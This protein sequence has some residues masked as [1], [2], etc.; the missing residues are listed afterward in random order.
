[1]NLVPHH[2]SHDPAPALPHRRRAI[3]ACI[4]LALLAGPV[5]AAPATCDRPNVS[6]VN[7]TGV[8]CGDGAVATGSGA[9]A[10]GYMSKAIGDNAIALGNAAQGFAG[11]SLALGAG[12]VVNAAA[13]GSIAL[14]A[15]SVA[16]GTT[17]ATPAYL[18]G[19]TAPS[20]L[21]IGGRRI[22]GVADGAN[23][24]D[25]AT[26]GQLKAANVG[27]DLAVRYAW[28]DA[29]G[30]KMVD[31]GEIDYS[32]VILG[33]DPKTGVPIAG[34]VTVS[35]VKNG[36]VD[37]TST[38]A[39]NGS[40]LFGVK[41]TADTALLTANKGWNVS[42]DSGAAAN[43]GPGGNVAFHSTDG[44][45]AVSQSGKA[46]AGQVDLTLSRNL[47]LDS[48]T[49][50]GTVMNATGLTITGGPSVTVGGINANTTRISNLAAGVA[51]GDAVN[52]SQLG[53]VRKIAETGWDVSDEAGS[54]ANI[55]PDGKITFKSADSNLAVAQKGEDDNGVIEVALARNLDLGAAGSVTMGTTTVDAA[56]LA[57]TGGPSVTTT[58]IS[59]GSQAITNVANGVADT[60]AVNV[61]QL[62]DVRKTAEA[63]WN[64][65]DRTGSQV[66]IGANGK[67]TFQSADA[68]LGVVQKGE[69]DEGVVEVQLAK[70]LDLG[71][72]GSVV[73]GTTTVNAAG[74]AIT[75]GPSVTTTGID[76]GTKTIINV[77]NGVADNDAVNMSQ[78]EAVKKSAS[79]GWNVA[80][81]SGNAANISPE[82][83][84]TFQSADANLAVTQKG[85]DDEGIVEV[86]LAKNLD[87]GA[88]GSMAMG[89][90]TINATG[91]FI[92]GGPSVTTT[93]INAG[94]KVVTNLADGV[95]DS[96]AVNMSQLG[97]VSKA[98][99]A[100]WNVADEAGNQ[101]NI[102]P[103]GTVTFKSAD[104]NLTVTQKGGNDD[105]VVE[106]QLAKNLDLGA[107][108]SVAMGTTTV[109][110]TG[111]T[112]AGGPSVTTTGINAGSRVIT[113]VAN[114]VSDTDAVNMAQLGEV[115]NAANAGWMVSDA[116][117]S[118]AKIGPEGVVTFESADAN[119][120]VTQTGGDGAGVVAFELSR[121]LDLGT[122]GSVA[123]GD[124]MVDATGMK[125]AN[126]PSVTIAGIDAGSKVITNVAAGQLSETSTD[127]VNGS[128]LYATNQAIQSIGSMAGNANDLA[129]KYA[130]SDTNGD[131]VATSDEIDYGTVVLSGEQGTRI[132]NLAP[133]LVSAG[134][135]DAI[136]GSQLF[137]GMTQVAN[138]FGGGAAMTPQGLTAPDYLVLGQSYSN[139]GDALQALDQGVTLLDARMTLISNR[140]VG[141]QLA[142]YTHGQSSSDYPVY[143]DGGPGSTALGVNAHADGVE[144]AVAV[145]E[146]ATV[147]ANYGTAVG[148]GAST[149]A[150]NAVALGHGAVA[151]RADTVSVGTVGG[152]RQVVNVADA[153]QDTDAVNKRQ[154]DRGVASANGYTDARVNAL[155]DSFE[156]F[157]GNVDQRLR[158]QDQR[159]D[160]QGAMSAAMMNMAVS[161]AGIHTPNRV[162]VGVGFQG[163]ESA[164]SLGYQRAF[165]DRATITFGG[166]FSSDD[167]AVGIGAGFGW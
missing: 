116:G 24:D 27:N 42:A 131:G 1:M 138:Y 47:A 156:V 49:T 96:D 65:S 25:A 64:V 147:A 155:S 82:G 23:N 78:L 28:N 53:D 54:K 137:A 14:G 81:K 46:N 44:N 36:A 114:G 125:I 48:V 123:M 71:T 87:L 21:A 57:I 98:A 97:D 124:T 41:Q 84:V 142:G 115:S 100:G 7:G 26:V 90:T 129:V 148:Q 109:N 154:L 2:S 149:V 153:T 75:G 144:D 146:S 161:A 74:L 66:N 158:K 85:E 59:A 62:A 166:A 127:A 10:V 45:L 16:S 34:G 30:N 134:S 29:N 93:G 92:A 111:L 167:Q 102:G 83:S 136:N 152:E 107:T 121:N 126:G 43:I 157:Q 52:V 72:A 4:A 18:T 159:I 68:N 94:A 73:M 39:V 69:D 162:G 135:M 143:G 86:A 106:V 119:L 76:A 3:A 95:A 35:N 58:G 150:D 140:P 112:I 141:S 70:N 32:R 101:V 9:V 19:Q 50:G 12:A 61:A 103:D 40:Q 105:G 91:V 22:T 67:V 6:N 51:A 31:A 117:G 145:G 17:L 108:G 130:W 80:D 15:G 56:G 11:N 104:A 77:A 118:T 151:D 38:E 128:Q 37:S 55:G 139:V 20:E 163:G 99:N 133:G 8:G 120:A 79:A 113:N 88:S 63:G 110:A 122:S 164:L 160:R 132:G 33:A 89:A 60:D 5:Y 165:S 13:T